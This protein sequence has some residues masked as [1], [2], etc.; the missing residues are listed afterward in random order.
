MFPTIFVSFNVPLHKI[1][2]PEVGFVI[3]DFVFQSH[4]TFM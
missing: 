3:L 1:D 4:Q 2:S